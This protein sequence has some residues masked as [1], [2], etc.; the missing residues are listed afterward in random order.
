[1]RAACIGDRPAAEA[2]DVE[3]QDAGGVELSQDRAPLVAVA[4][5]ADPEGRQ[6]VVPEFLDRLGLLAEQN[7]DDVLAAEALAGA[8]DRRHRLLRQHGAVDHGDAAGADIA[9]A[10]W[11]GALAEIAEQGLAAAARRLAERDERVEA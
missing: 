7:A 9:V 11:A 6:R 8:Q 10:A 5:L 4:L 2:G 1:Q 3:R